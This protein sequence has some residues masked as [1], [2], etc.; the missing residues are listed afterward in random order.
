MI[1][2]DELFSDKFKYEHLA[3]NV[4]EAKDDDVLAFSATFSNANVD[5]RMSPGLME[6]NETLWLQGSEKRPEG[7]VVLR[8]PSKGET[9]TTVLASR[10]WFY[11]T[12]DREGRDAF[13]ERL[14][15]EV[16]KKS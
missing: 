8:S 5:G 7:F 6:V 3:V 16:G 9:T 14:D 4:L 15:K 13:D 12:L 10:E 1:K 11:H 2:R